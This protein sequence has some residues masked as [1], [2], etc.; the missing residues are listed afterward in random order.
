MNIDNLTPEL[1]SEVLKLD[2][3]EDDK[4]FSELLKINS[5]SNNVNYD[6]RF[7]KDIENGWT[8]AIGN[9]WI[10]IYEF[11]DKLLSFIYEKKYGVDIKINKSL[12]GKYIQVVL[13]NGKSRP[14]IAGGYGERIEHLIDAVQWILDNKEK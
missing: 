10:N 13:I 1:L 12:H 3:Y 5:I 7:L 8:E 4:K 11:E 6:I 9:R 14:Y 2:V